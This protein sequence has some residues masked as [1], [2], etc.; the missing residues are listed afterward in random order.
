MGISHCSCLFFSTSCAGHSL[1]CSITTDGG[2]F[3]KI[4]AIGLFSVCRPNSQ[5]LDC[6]SFHSISSIKSWLLT[7]YPSFPSHSSFLPSHEHLFSTFSVMNGKLLCWVMSVIA[8]GVDRRN[9][10]SQGLS[11]P[12]APLL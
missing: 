10:G 1:N 2:S 6:Y 9:D 11:T 4:K 3:I 8:I 7:A 12:P 5:L